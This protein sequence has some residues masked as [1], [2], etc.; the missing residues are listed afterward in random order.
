MPKTQAPWPLSTPRSNKQRNKANDARKFDSK[1][2][3]RGVAVS[4][5]IEALRSPFAGHHPETE[6]VCAPELTLAE[7]EQLLDWLENNGY[8]DNRISYDPYKG[9]TVEYVAG[10]GCGVIHPAGAS[11]FVVHSEP[12]G[13]IVP[14]STPAVAVPRKVVLQ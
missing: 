10:H 14:H 13:N 6:M 1:S 5:T 7:S 11:A 9:F 8:L 3:R 2:A 4:P 12:R